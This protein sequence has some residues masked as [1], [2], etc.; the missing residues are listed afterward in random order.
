[1]RGGG[2]RGDGAGSSE[3][4][5]EVEFRRGTEWARGQTG[6]EKKEWGVLGGFMVRCSE[7]GVVGGIVE[8]WAC[9]VADSVEVVVVV[10]DSRTTR[11][12]FSI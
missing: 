11:E 2:L 4:V 3:E 9:L 8:T 1:M 10:E 6:V 7:S 12:D 5:E